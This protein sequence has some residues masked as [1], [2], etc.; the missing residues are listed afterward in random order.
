MIEF[1][2]GLWKLLTSK[3]GMACV[4]L[5]L[6]GVLVWRIYDA[7][8]DSMREET[9]KAVAAA[10]AETKEWKD[11]HS[12]I[13]EEQ[14]QWQERLGEAVQTATK[15]QSVIISDL[16]EQL[17]AAK[18]QKERVKVVTKEVVRYV[19]QQSDS[20]CTVPAGF[21]WLYDY[22]LQSS[23]SVPLSKPG[24]VDAPSGVALSAVADVA[25][26]NNAECIERGN[27]IAAWQEW[28]ERN[29]ALNKAVMDAAA[30]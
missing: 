11:K 9:A 4:G 18:A 28:Y 26:S 22:S 10:K 20:A 13:K 7:G 27:V 6:I 19:T 16:G 25:A 14:K 30:R 8:R 29:L 2:I 24:N 17:A 1:F 5:V 15:G 21:V 3:I 12:A 23:G